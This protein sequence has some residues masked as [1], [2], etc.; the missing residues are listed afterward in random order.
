MKK[1]SLKEWIIRLLI[2]ATIGFAIA[3]FWQQMKNN[4]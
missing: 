3:Y 2:Y 4:R 1:R